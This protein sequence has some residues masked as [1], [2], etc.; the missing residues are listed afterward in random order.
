MTDLSNNLII[1]KDAETIRKTLLINTFK[2][3]VERK[4]LNADRWFKSE[5]DK[6]VPSS[7]LLT[8]TNKTNESMVYTINLDKDI[9]KNSESNIDGKVLK[10]KIIYQNITGLGTSPILVEFIKDYDKFHKL[11][12]VDDI[13]DKILEYIYTLQ[14]IEIFKKAMLMINIVEYICSPKY[15]ILSDEECDQ[16]MTEYDIKKKELKKM[17]DTDPISRYYNLKKGQIARIIRTS[18]QTGISIDYRI[19]IKK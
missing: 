11:I 3:L 15:E 7:N 10:L 19:V 12:I 14:N 17:Y 18:K 16:M 13:A 9:N 5:N 1:I 6:L 4:W 2:M 8:F